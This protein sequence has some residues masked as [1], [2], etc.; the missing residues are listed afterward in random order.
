M[1]SG[2]L[3]INPGV[4]TTLEITLIS[5]SPSLATFTSSL[6]TKCATFA[7]PAVATATLGVRGGAVDLERADL[8]LDSL[9]QY[10]VIASIILGSMV[11]KLLEAS[12]LIPNVGIEFLT[13]CPF[14]RFIWRYSARA[15]RRRG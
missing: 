15:R 13:R 6:A 12:A 7:L 8:R 11:G 2:M 14:S 9:A 5:S 1:I 3:S 10:G 4:A